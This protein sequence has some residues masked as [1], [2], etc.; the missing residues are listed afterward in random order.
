M[1]ELVATA[2]ACCANCLTSYPLHEWQQLQFLAPEGVTLGNVE[3]ERRTCHTCGEVVIAVVDG[4]PELGVWLDPQHH[5][6]LYPM[7]T[8]EPIEIAPPPRVAALAGLVLAV[9]VA[10]AMMT[11]IVRVV[12]SA[13]S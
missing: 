7:S 12:W 5:R 6:E 11:A 3:T 9:V 2:I 4:L 8:Q 1:T 10:V 13:F